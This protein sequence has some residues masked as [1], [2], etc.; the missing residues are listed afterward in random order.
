MD[1][2]SSLAKFVHEKLTSA[3][4]HSPGSEIIR[5]LLHVVYTTSMKKEESEPLKCSVVYLDPETKP[6]GEAP[7]ADTWNAFRLAN[8]VPL[9]S[10]NLSKLCRAADPNAAILAGFSDDKGKLFIWGFVDQVALHSLRMTTWEAWSSQ[11]TPGDFH[12]IANGVADITVYHGLSILA[13]LKQD[14]LVEKYDDVLNKGPVCEHLCRLASQ[15]AAQ[16]ESNF[17]DMP[18]NYSIGTLA[19]HLVIALSRILL[20]IQKYKHGGAL[21]I[22]GDTK[23]NLSIKHGLVYDRLPRAISNFSIQALREE[24]CNHYIYD[25]LLPQKKSILPKTFREY[26][27][28]DFGCRES[29]SEMAGCVKFIASL[30]RIDGLVLMDRSL[31]VHGFGVEIIDVPEVETLFAAE[32]E[33]GKNLRK[34]QSSVPGTARCSGTAMRTETALVLSSRKTGSYVQSRKLAIS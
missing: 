21:L 23:T 2:I 33:N 6:E 18:T 27:R 13:A 25:H 7:G 5:D 32:D 28:A 4:Y 29:K 9:D 30:S 24:N 1:Q 8:P 31:V 10:R 34:I 19:M 3:Q 16:V 26:V 14:V 22:T 20:S 15:Y 12:V 11:A 17:P